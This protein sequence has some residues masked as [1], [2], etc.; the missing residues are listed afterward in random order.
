MLWLYC[1]I[2]RK[3]GQFSKIPFEGFDPSLEDLCQ[4]LADVP[5]GKV[6]VGVWELFDEHFWGNDMHPEYGR[7]VFGRYHN[8]EAIHKK[9]VAFQKRGVFGIKEIGFRSNYYYSRRWVRLE[10]Y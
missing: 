9:M 8:P 10:V 7:V 5:T 1:L 3:Q 4:A 2:K 6:I